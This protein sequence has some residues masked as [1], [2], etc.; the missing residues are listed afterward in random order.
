MTFSSKAVQ[1]A[2]DDN[3]SKVDMNQEFLYWFSGFTGAEGNFLISIDRNYIKLRF[4][5][6]LHIDDLEVLQSNLNIGRIIEEPNKNSCF[7]LL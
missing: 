3:I 7:F 4:K 6:N 1:C 5:I 2:L